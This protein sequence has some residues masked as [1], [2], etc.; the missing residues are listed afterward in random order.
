MQVKNIIL[1]FSVMLFAMV[2]SAQKKL[3]SQTDYAQEISKTIMHKWPDS[4]TRLDGKSA[5][6]SYDIGLYLEAIS[7][8]YARTGNKVYFDY[9]QKQMD[10]FLLPDGQIKFYK[11]NSYNIDYVRNG[12]AMMYL[13]ER[14]GEQKYANAAKY[15]RQQLYTHPRTSEGGF[16]HKKVYP[17]QMWLDGLYMGQPFYA[18]FSK[19][20][21]QPENFDDIAK[22][23]ILM[24]KHSRDSETGLLHHAWDESRQQRW[25]DKQTGK[26]PNIWGRAMGWYGVALVDVLDDFPKDHP[27]RK[28]LLEILNRYVEAV[29][30][31]QN[32]TNDLWY[33]VLDKAS[34]KGNYPEASA[35]SM[36]VYT[37]L[38]GS[39]LGYIPSKYRDVAKKGY[40][41]IIKQFIE[42]GDDGFYHLN[43]TVMVSGLGGNPYRDGSFEYYISEP[44]IQDDPKGMG[45]F[46]LAANEVTL[47]K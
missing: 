35:S 22:Q 45:A 2:C 43:G 40:Q 14:T 36:F 3:R 17:N 5:G 31:V 29:A 12:K 42:K 34:K 20:F 33:Q 38:K 27:Q 11:Q 25:A 39:R 7:N 41:G 26:S 23:F 8:V 10:R 4:L 24:E 18:H 32:P 28:T 19:V 37:M 13:F 44:V 30:K 1:G 6:W 15:I 16:W 46:I 9:I 21:N 47:I